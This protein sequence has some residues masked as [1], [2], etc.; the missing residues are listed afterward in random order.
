MSEN[1]PGPNI[2]RCSKCGKAYS[3]LTSLLDPKSGK[4]VRLFRCE[5]GEHT[6]RD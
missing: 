4:T 6:W 2:L 5:C 3:L 1:Q